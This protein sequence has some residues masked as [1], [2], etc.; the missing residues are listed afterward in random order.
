MPSI[1]TLRVGIDAGGTFTDFVAVLPNGQMHYHK[2]PSNPADPS[3]PVEAGLRG[4]LQ[5][6]AIASQTR[7]LLVVHGTTI[8]LNAVLQGKGARTAVLVTRGLRD[9]LEIER[10]RLPNHLSLH[11]VKPDPIVSRD[12]VLELGAR[13]DSNGEITDFP[14]A[15][16]FDA[17]CEEIRRLAPEAVAIVLVNAYISPKLEASVE[18]EIKA[19][20]PDLLVTCSASVWPELREYERAVIAC[21]NAKVHPLMEAYL[22]SLETRIAGLSTKSKLQLSTSSGGMLSLSGALERPIETMLS[23]PASGT[24]AASR[25]ARDLGIS[26]GITFDMGGTSAD[27]AILTNAKVEFTTTSHIGALPLMMPVIGVSSIG[28]GGGSIL[29]IDSAGLLKV[30]PESAGSRPGPVAFGLGGTEATV[31]DCYIALGII[32]PTNFLGGRMTL[33]VDAALAALDA[34]AKRLGLASAQA[35]AEAALNIA[36][37]G[38][39][40]ELFKLLA[41]GGHDPNEHVIM[42]FGGAGPT[43]AVMLAD[44]AGLPGVAVPPAAATFCA[45]GAVMADAR[46]DYLRSIGQ[47]GW[48]DLPPK[49]WS[50]WSEMRAEADAWF[51]AE[52][53]TVR[54]HRFEYQI[55]MRYA[56]QSHNMIVNVDESVVASKD[57]AA[58]AEAFHK[59]HEALYDFHETDEKVEAVSV[60]LSIIAM[61]QEVALATLAPHQ[62]EAQPSSRRKIFHRGA[63]VDSAVYQRSALGAGATFTGP[64]VVEQSDTTTWVPPGWTVVVHPTGTLL[65]NRSISR[66]A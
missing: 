43:Q 25:L 37:V 52:D 17:V 51:A 15:A 24:V 34:V 10:G 63:W 35:A 3:A 42:P 48:Y 31:T 23:G 66:E 33:D 12:L 26:S 28:A 38:M 64:A 65:I 20:I 32:D 57:L 1:G 53:M 45:L 13:A 46:R 4:L 11:A 55:D 58:V 30:G 2:E 56:G 62:G 50:A 5:N 49:I 21:L 39:S 18:R 8:G 44:D 40:T 7:D 9:V 27:I 47:T 59:S 54:G 41:Q 14:E 19:R 22:H 16:E 60:R 61:V 36:T 29:K 6:E